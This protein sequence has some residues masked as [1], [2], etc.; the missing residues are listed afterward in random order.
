MQGNS[1]FKSFSWGIIIFV[2]NL[3]SAVFYKDSSS[4]LS[5]RQGC[6][7]P[8]LRA[9]NSLK[10]LSIVVITLQTL[11]LIKDWNPVPGCKTF[12]ILANELRTI[13]STSLNS[14]FLIPMDLRFD[15]NLSSTVL[16]FNLEI[17]PYFV[18]FT[19]YLSFSLTN[20]SRFWIKIIGLLGLKPIKVGFFILYQLLLASFNNHS[21]IYPSILSLAHNNPCSLL[22]T[23]ID[24]WL[25]HLD[26]I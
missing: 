25:F 5:P 19:V 13:L 23:R 21:F 26:L 3:I 22:F 18:K 2:M 14:F 4:S 20:V 24:Y 16:I 17:Y 12:K 8:L 10:F 6:S 9:I 15:P 1:S 11:I 7:C